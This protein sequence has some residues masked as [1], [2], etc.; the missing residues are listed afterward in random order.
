[1]SDK[2][3]LESLSHEEAFALS[4]RF[5]LRVTKE[6]GCGY[7][8]TAE[9]IIGLVVWEETNRAR[10][11]SDWLDHALMDG[12]IYKA[13]AVLYDSS[14]DY[15]RPQLI[16][17]AKQL[18]IQY[19][20]RKKKEELIA[21]IEACIAPSSGEGA[22]TSSSRSSDVGSIPSTASPIKYYLW[23]CGEMTSLIDQST[24]PVFLGSKDSM[25]DAVSFVRR[26]FSPTALLNVVDIDASAPFAL[27]SPFEYGEK[28]N[29]RVCVILRSAECAKVDADEIVNCWAFV[30]TAEEHHAYAEALLVA[31]IAILLVTLR[32][33]D[34]YHFIWSTNKRE[35]VFVGRRKTVEEVIASI[36]KKDGLRF[37]N[38]PS[39]E[40]IAEMIAV[41]V[42][43]MPSNPEDPRE[44]L[45]PG[46]THREWRV[47]Q[48]GSIFY[49]AFIGT[50]E[51]HEVYRQTV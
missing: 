11:V 49:T 51:E 41:P 19:T 13:N 33:N 26:T 47:A 17:F 23:A 21:D 38:P 8:T 2:R 34:V 16:V 6:G 24:K 42:P 9:L 50:E 36:E 40:H 10:L 29:H 14:K 30:G 12:R 3:K 39:D 46:F 27:G 18:G 35:V 7:K 25:S 28:A 20:D 5:G 1:M 15:T 48:G 44:S 45:L 32:R 43:K 22:S 4:K 31:P 37:E